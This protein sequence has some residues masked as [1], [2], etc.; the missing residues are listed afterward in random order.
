[1]LVILKGSPYTFEGLEGKKVIARPSLHGGC[2]VSIAELYRVC[3]NDPYARDSYNVNIS[4][5]LCLHLPKEFFELVPPTMVNCSDSN[6]GK[7]WD[8]FYEQKSV[9]R[10]KF[11]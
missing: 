3:S 4:A 11:R 8:G 10:S 1:M 5:N 6:V 9:K 7:G 2:Q